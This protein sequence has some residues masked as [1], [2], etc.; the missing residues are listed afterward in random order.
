MTLRAL[1]V[2]PYEEVHKEIFE[3]NEKAK[4][5]GIKVSGDVYH[6]LDPVRVP[7]SVAI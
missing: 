3:R 1:P 4:E 2:S 7:N 5:K 6:Y